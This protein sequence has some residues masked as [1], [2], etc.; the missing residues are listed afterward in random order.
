MEKEL[1]TLVVHYGDH[2][3]RCAIEYKGYSHRRV[4]KAVQRQI[5]AQALL[6]NS[7]SEKLLEY[8][9][10]KANFARFKVLVDGCRKVYVDVHTC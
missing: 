7:S 4:V 2:L 3:D 5:A 10:P 6:E 8:S 1:S 9:H